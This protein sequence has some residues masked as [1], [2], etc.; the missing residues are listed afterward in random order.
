MGTANIFKELILI[1]QVLT[2]RTKAKNPNKPGKT[3][4]EL[5]DEALQ[6]IN[7]L[8]STENF[9]PTARDVLDALYNEMVKY[10]ATDA[11]E[12]PS[13]EEVAQQLLP[14]ANLMYELEQNGIADEHA[15]KLAEIFN[16]RRKAL[17][18]L[19]NYSK[20]QPDS[21]QIMHDACV[22]NIPDKNKIDWNTWQKLAQRNLT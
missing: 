9:P 10:T 2:N 8:K 21:N 3:S 20:Q 1:E 17:A 16:D 22:F 7:A 13:V 19:T 18:Y 4:E 11:R 15:R 5:E 14:W 12:K 6:K